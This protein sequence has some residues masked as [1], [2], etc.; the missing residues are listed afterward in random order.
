MINVNPLTKTRRDK[1][2][3]VF[4]CIYFCYETLCVSASPCLCE[5][6]HTLPTWT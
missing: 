3:E 5:I 1:D 6:E 4:Y 2:T